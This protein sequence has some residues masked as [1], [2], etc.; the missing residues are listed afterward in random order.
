[1][2]TYHMDTHI[3]FGPGKAAELPRLLTALHFQGPLFVVTDRGLVAA[4]LVEPLLRQLS[5]AGWQ[6][7][8]F[9]DV[10]PNPRDNDCVQGAAQFSAVGAKTVLAIG[11]GS[12][13]DTAKAIALLAKHGGSPADYVDGRRAYE[14][15]YP[16]VCVPTTA[17]TGSE[18]TRSAVIT[19]ADTHRKMTL[20]HACLRPTLAVLDPTLTHT[21]P[22]AVTAATGVDALVHAIEGSTCTV[23]TP[24]A[25]AFGYAAMPIIVRALPRAVANG[26][27]AQAREDM[28]LASLMAGLCFGNTDV[29]AV[30]CL[31]EALGGLYDTPHGVANAVFLPYVLRYNAEGCPE[32]HADLARRMQFAS[33]TDSTSVAVD[34]L[35]SG[36]AR[37]TADLGI[38]KLRE[39]PGVNPDD[40][41]KLVELAYANGSTPSNVRSID[42][43]GYRMLLEQAFADR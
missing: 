29:A 33:A 18:V 15:A 20:K 8:L 26:N 7:T 27:D 9:T 42:R 22:P 41:P 31:A 34:K 10:R 28:L 3:E 32:V 4:G 13:I 24:I 17:G 36:I 19:E 5:N 35:V 14:G 25:Q 1:M 21:L 11:G 37:W 43:E 39:L 12:A 16:I 30:H 38:P 23:T 6:T 2:F 40:F